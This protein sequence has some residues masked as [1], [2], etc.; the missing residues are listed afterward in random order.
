MRI[1]SSLP[2]ESTRRLVEIIGEPSR[3]PDIAKP[4]RATG[5][6]QIWWVTIEGKELFVKLWFPR[7]GLRGL[8]EV[9][10]V[11]PGI[12]VWETARRLKAAGVEI[13][14]SVAAGEKRKAA[15]RL[16]WSF[17]A[18]ERVLD[19]VPL[20]DPAAAAPEWPAAKR[21][22]FARALGVAFARLLGKGFHQ[23]DFKPTNFLVRGKL[24]AALVGE[25]SLVAID[26]RRCSLVD[27]KRALTD[28]KT[29]EQLRTRV[30]AGWPDPLQ[31]V[32]RDAMSWSA[33]APV[34][35]RA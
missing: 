23:P 22:S 18:C 28:P 24:D 7:M 32:F 10:R 5:R 17:Y 20:V 4:F 8:K 2:E 29:L 9:L 27:P 33:V 14:K 1:E 13:P 35:K 3:F 6:K 15:R 30:L 34:A 16:A 21:D 26:L 12:D 25:L 31:K 19:A 11:S